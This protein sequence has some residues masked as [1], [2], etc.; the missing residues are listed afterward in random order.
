[1]AFKGTGQNS[2]FEIQLKSFNKNQLGLTLLLLVY[3]HVVIGT[4]I[5]VKNETEDNVYTTHFKDC[6]Y[7]AL[8]FLWIGVFNVGSAKQ[9]YVLILLPYRSALDCIIKTLTAL[10]VIF[11]KD[12]SEF[13]F[14]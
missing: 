5:K 10:Q 7:I 8:K 9:K 11:F 13:E 14:T 2:K 6:Y 3:I 1:M 12:S 4:I